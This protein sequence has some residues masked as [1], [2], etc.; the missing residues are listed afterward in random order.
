MLEQHL[1]VS[2]DKTRELPDDQVRSRSGIL[3]I[4]DDALIAKPDPH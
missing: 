1:F 3:S 4:N 2:S